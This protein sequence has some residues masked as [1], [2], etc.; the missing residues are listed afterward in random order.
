MHLFCARFS[1]FS[2][3][4]GL[5]NSARF[6]SRLEGESTISFRGSIISVCFKVVRISPLQAY[7]HIPAASLVHY[8]AYLIWTSPSPGKFCLSVC[9]DALSP[10]LAFFPL[11][12]F[13]PVEHNN[14]VL[15]SILPFSCPSDVFAHYRLL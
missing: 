8:K 6:F 3:R 7:M 5:V 15:P 2:V 11:S 4:R 12:L 14:H 10:K 9:A 13:S 1:F